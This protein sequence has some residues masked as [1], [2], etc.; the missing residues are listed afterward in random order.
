MLDMVALVGRPNVG[1]STLFNG[2]T[3]TRDALVHDEPGVTRDRHYGYCRLNPERPFIVCDTGG[4]SGEDEGLA[5]ATSKQSWLAAEEAALILF[6]VDA[7]TGPELLD[8]EILLGLRK[9]NK[10]MI[11][12]INKV[13]TKNSNDTINDFAAFGFQYA[14]PIASAHQQGVPELLELITSLLPKQIEQEQPIDDGRLRLAFIGRPNVGKST[15]V[16]RLLGEERVIASDVPGTTRDSIAIDLDRDGREYR[17]I[18]TAGLRKRG[19]REEAVE[20]FSVFKTMQSIQDCQVAVVL[21]DAGEGVTE[22]DATVLGHV[23]DSGRA[24]VIAVNKWDNQ[25]TY[26]REQTKSLLDRK[27]SF[28]TW[29]PIVTISAKHGTGMAEL[30]KLIH[31]AYDSATYKFTTAEVTKAID[32]AYTTF[33]PPVVRGHVAKMKYGHPGNTNPPTFIIHGNRLKT[34]P[35]SYRRYLENFFRKRFKL[36]GTPIRFVFKDG[37]N[38]YEGKKNVLTDRQ[39]EKR[40][41]LIRHNKRK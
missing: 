8:H 26:Q 34:L 1:K 39:M 24:L 25:S 10:P 36:I 19:K 33:P 11:L 38:P 23:L 16:N 9:L 40:K 21:L 17:L 31:K 12:V 20:K 6:I 13:D 15:L 35:D 14:I 27:L 30:F 2:L 37:E 41:R 4:V 32:I 29:A 5:G 7:K 28:C 3:R 22:Q 18:D